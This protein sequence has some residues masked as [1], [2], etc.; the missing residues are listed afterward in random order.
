MAEELI[1]AWCSMQKKSNCGQVSHKLLIVWC[2][3]RQS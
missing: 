3:H 1:Q 2:W